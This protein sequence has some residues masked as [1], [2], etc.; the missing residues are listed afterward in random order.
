MTTEQFVGTI[1]QRLEFRVSAVASWQLSRV[2]W[3]GYAVLGLQ[4]VGF[5]VWS[6]IQYQRFAVTYDFSMFHQAWYLI[7][8]GELDPYSTIK[9]QP[10]WQ[11][12]SEFLV[13]P[14][15]LLY[16][17]YPQ[18]VMLLWV[19]DACVVL[20]ELMV[21]TWICSE[22]RKRCPGIDAAW[23]SGL[24]I[25]L[26]AANPW[27]WWSIGWDFHTETL[28]MPFA[29]MLAWDLMEGR[30]RVWVWV[31]PLLACGDVAATYV[32][33]LGL[34]GVLIRP[35]CRVRGAILVGVG[36]V[37]TAIITVVHGNLGSGGG[38]QAYRYI[39][40]A[41]SGTRLGLAALVKAIATHPSRLAQVLWSKRLDM[42][43][44]LG[45]SGLLGAG[46][47]LLLPLTAVVLLADFLYPGL[48][49]AVPGFQNLPV[50]IFVPIGTVCVL[51][52]LAQRHRRVA[53]LISGLMA[54]QALGWAMVWFPG[55]PSQ[56]LR[57]SAPAA[58]TLMEIQAQI[59][60]SATAIV[61]QGVVGRFAGRAH[62]EVLMGPGR[63]PVQAVETWFVVAPTA[64]IE[65]MS[66]ASAM[67]L[68]GEL[69]GPLHAALVIHAN[70]VWAFRWTPPPGI[71]QI[72]VRGGGPPR[73]DCRFSPARFPA[74]I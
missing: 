26:L 70:G 72:T 65:T 54:A 55:T 25:F 56:W 52:W 5:I 20:A 23:L 36:I 44:D 19:Q 62:V 59:P 18:G 3:A 7:A 33:G 16:W 24:G 39:A 51:A 50:Y 67:A 37:A 46:F 4:F 8:H 58:A 66:T 31:V 40:G 47:P 2:Q 53:L 22:A 14:L 9:Y 6:T 1:R 12:H 30:R 21:F 73:P 13:W 15:A 48:L 49:F 45:P 17:I 60:E 41:P 34:G 10:F 69:A 29:V 61:S 64:G 57:V 11:D 43:A 42:W 68:I 27:I 35:Q 74:G 28:A 32:A 71:S 63:L 38:L